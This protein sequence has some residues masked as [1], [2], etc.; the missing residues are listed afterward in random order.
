MKAYPKSDGAPKACSGTFFHRSEAYPKP[1]GLKKLVPAL[2]SIARKFI[3]KPMD[4]KKLLSQDSSIA[5]ECFSASMVKQGK[6]I[7]ST[8]KYSQREWSER[9]GS[10]LESGGFPSWQKLSKSRWC[11]KPK[12]TFFLSLRFKKAC[13][14]MGY[15][16]PTSFFIP[17]DMKRFLIWWSPDIKVGKPPQRS[18]FPRCGQTTPKVSELK[19]TMVKYSASI[20]VK[21]R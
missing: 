1:D 8:K 14:K 10:S 9:P 4:W 5:E 2:F 15:S 6:G 17:S 19:C 7:P 16:H 20:Q 12:V 11:L 13:P 21:G 18:F 3:S